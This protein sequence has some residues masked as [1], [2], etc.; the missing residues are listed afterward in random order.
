MMMMIAFYYGHFQTSTE[1]EGTITKLSGTRHPFSTVT[2]QR[3]GYHPHPL[4]LSRL[5]PVML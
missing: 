5:C 2:S 3:D 4:Q 1:V